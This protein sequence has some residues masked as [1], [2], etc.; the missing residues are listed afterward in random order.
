MGEAPYVLAVNSDDVTYKYSIAL[1]DDN[2]EIVEGAEEIYV[3]HFPEKGIYTIITDYEQDDEG[4]I[5]N[6]RTFNK[7][8]FKDVKPLDKAL[9]PAEVLN[10]KIKCDT[11][12]EWDSDNPITSGAVYE[13]KHNLEYSKQDKILVDSSQD[14]SHIIGIQDGKVTPVYFDRKLYVE[15]LYEHA[16][17]LAYF[18]KDAYMIYSSR[19]EQA[20]KALEQILYYS[21]IISENNGKVVAVVN[22]KLDL[23]D[24]KDLIGGGT[25][26]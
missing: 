14:N 15:M 5:S 8:F 11:S 7:I 13:L 2:G 18:D 4:N 17:K 3:L 10:P 22:G 16:Q 23:V 24:I 20:Y 1:R 19:A 6:Y 25:N 12:P 9:L 26:A 21:K